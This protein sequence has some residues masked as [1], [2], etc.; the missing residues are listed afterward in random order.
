MHR[1]MFAKLN[2]KFNQF[3]LLNVVAIKRKTTHTQNNPTN[4]NKNKIKT[5]M[6]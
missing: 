1:H 2:N 3:F 5:I 4:K 6:N